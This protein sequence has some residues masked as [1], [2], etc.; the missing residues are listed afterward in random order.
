M[1][2]TVDLLFQSQFF[3]FEFLEG[4]VIWRRSVLLFIEHPVEVGMFRLERRDPIIKRHE[5]P[6]LVDVSERYVMPSSIRLTPAA[7]PG[8]S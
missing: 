7:L 8:Q 5:T 1:M 2:E 4:S 3:E 6:L